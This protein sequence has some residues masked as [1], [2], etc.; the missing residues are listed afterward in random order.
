[1]MHNSKAMAT[2]ALLFPRLQMLCKLRIKIPDSAL[3]QIKANL[4]KFI[5]YSGLL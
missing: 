2:I 1:M 5:L 4:T 3:V